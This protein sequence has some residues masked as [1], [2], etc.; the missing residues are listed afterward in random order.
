[1]ERA[2]SER[3]LT[4]LLFSPNKLL[5]PAKMPAMMLDVLPGVHT[6][7]PSASSTAAPLR[8][9]A[10]APLH[11]LRRCAVSTAPPQPTA[12]F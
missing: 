11:T 3:G 6:K 9:A 8:S 4:C 2:H 5:I 10:R 7:Q 12:A 1:M